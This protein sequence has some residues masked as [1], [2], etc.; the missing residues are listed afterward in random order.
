M[1]SEFQYHIPCFLTESSNSC[2]DNTGN[3]ARQKS[4]VLINLSGFSHPLFYLLVTDEAQCVHATNWLA[5]WK[6]R[7]L[8]FEGGQYILRL[9]KMMSYSHD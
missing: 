2:F 9:Q 3:D 7:M 1:T 4:T 8:V 5:V 6:Y